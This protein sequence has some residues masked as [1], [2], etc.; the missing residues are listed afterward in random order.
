[1]ERWQATAL[2]N[3]RELVY[4]KLVI[5]KLIREKTVELI[6]ADPEKAQVLNHLIAKMKSMHAKIRE[7]ELRPKKDVLRY[8]FEIETVTTQAEENCLEMKMKGAPEAQLAW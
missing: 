6:L 8:I 7:P 4:E 1:M 3:V 2:E 5:P